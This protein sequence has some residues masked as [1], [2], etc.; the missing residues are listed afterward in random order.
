MLR[1]IGLPELIVIVTA[2]GVPI[3]IVIV[4]L[5]VVA[6]ARRPNTSQPAATLPVAGFCSKCGARLAQG[7]IFCASCGTRL[8]A[9]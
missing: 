6:L 2:L 8:S 5:A 1:S 7:V 3:M 9:S 4:V